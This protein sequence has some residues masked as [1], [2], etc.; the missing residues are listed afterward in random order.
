MSHNERESDRRR[1]NRERHERQNRS[2]GPE[3]REARGHRDVPETRA[4]PP[5]GTRPN[6]SSPHRDIGDEVDLWI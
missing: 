2:A 4:I 5:S 3:A 1:K 6:T